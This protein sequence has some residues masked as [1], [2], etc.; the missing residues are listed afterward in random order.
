MHGVDV[1]A[2]RE[3]SLLAAEQYTEALDALQ[4][5]IDVDEETKASGRGRAGVISI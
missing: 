1:W 3:R 5:A 2:K 4:K